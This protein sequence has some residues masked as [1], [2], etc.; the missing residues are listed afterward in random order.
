MI[1]LVLRNY[2]FFLISTLIL[3][4]LP[5]SSEVVL[6][7]ETLVKVDHVAGKI[8]K[9]KEKISLFLKIDKKRKADYLQFLAEKRLAELSYVIETDDINKIEETASRYSTYIGNF[10]NFVAE[11]KVSDKSDEI[12]DMFNRHAAVI[13]NLQAK[14]EFESGWWLALQQAEDATKIFSD[15]IKDL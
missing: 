6:A 3:F 7:Q 9:L 12:V 10:T 15:K 13:D 2:K 14:F 4:S 8:E 5:V 11:K 1:R